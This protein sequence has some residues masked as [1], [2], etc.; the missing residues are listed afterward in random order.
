MVLICSMHG[1]VELYTH[2]L[3][4]KPEGTRLFGNLKFRWADKC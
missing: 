2:G 1:K 4:G 3:V